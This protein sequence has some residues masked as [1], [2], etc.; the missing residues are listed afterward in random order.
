MRRHVAS[1]FTDQRIPN[2]FTELSEWLASRSGR[3]I[4]EKEQRNVLNM[5]LRGY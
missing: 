1:T 5:R 2:L 4:A 3:I